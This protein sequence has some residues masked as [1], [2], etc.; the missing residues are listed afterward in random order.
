MPRSNQ[1]QRK[2]SAT[3]LGLAA[4]ICSLVMGIASMSVLQ[5][6]ANICQPLLATRED[7]PDTLPLRA[8]VSTGLDDA[9][10]KLENGNYQ[11]SLQALSKAQLSQAFA[12][13]EA[14]YMKAMCLQSLGRFDKSAK[15]YSALENNYWLAKKAVL[16]RKL[17]EQKSRKLPAELTHFPASAEVPASE[18]F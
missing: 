2:I 5:A 6:L 1:Q 4:A 18:Q 10:E 17:A 9:A 11:G 12:I 14:Q 16:G 13:E 3:S 8:Y 15:E 7:P